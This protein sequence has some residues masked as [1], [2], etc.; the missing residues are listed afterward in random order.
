MERQPLLSHLAALRRTLLICAVAVLA[1]FLTVFLTASDALT[2][3]V[4]QPLTEQNVEVIFTGVAEAFG[5]KTKLSL[6]A[7]CVLASP[8]VLGALWAFVRPALYR[9]ERRFALALLL[10]ALLLFSVGVVFAYRYVFFLA[11]HFFVYSGDTLAQPLISLGTYVNFLFGFVVPFG[12]MFELPILI[13]GLSRLGIVTTDGLR[14]A[15]KYV[16]FAVFVVAAIL[17]PPDV[18]SQVMLGLPM[19]LLYELGVLCSWLFRPREKS[20]IPADPSAAS[21]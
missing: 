7:G 15:R 6:I 11:I 3:F 9:R 5:A 13:I 12:V 1:G 2:Q 21:M 20:E 10:V 4:I 14:K 8:V 16:I 18:V 17:T 19:C